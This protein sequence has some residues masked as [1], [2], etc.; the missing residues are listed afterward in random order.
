M[1]LTEMSA[2]RMSSEQWWKYEVVRLKKYYT[3]GTNWFDAIKSSPPYR[4]V[5]ILKFVYYFLD[6]IISTSVDS[7]VIW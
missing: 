1:P 7:D 3:I 4:F 2:V 5:W 6:A